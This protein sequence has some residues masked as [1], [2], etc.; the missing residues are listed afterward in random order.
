MTEQR[1]QVSITPKVLLAP[2]VALILLAGHAWDG[3]PGVATLAVVIILL[4][5]VW[6]AMSYAPT[7]IQ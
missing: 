4:A 5:M 7:R 6:F 1:A 2:I 3:W